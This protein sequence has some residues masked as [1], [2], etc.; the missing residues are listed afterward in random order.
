M[1]IQGGTEM[2]ILS[3]VTLNNGVEMPQLGF[4]VFQSA[5]GKETYQAVLWALEAGYRHIDTAM[6]YG[7]E[8]DVG[9]AIIDSGVPREEIFL[10]TKLWNEDMRQDRQE[11]A[12]QESLDRLQV[13][14]VDLY[15]IHWPVPGKFHDSWKALERIYATGKAKAIGVSNFQIHHLETIL[16]DAKIV[17]A[18]NQVELSPQLSQVPLTEYCNS[19]GIAVE[20]WSPLGGGVLV[21]DPRLAEIGAKY[22]K[23]AVQVILRWD[24]QRGIIT[25][26]KSVHQNR[27]IDNTK[28]FDFELSDEDMNYINS[29]NE[30]KRTGADPDTFNF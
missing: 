26:P 19:K 10:T 23:S 12:F 4:G 7:N 29:L 13:D 17:P 9:Q 25:I 30:D 14:Y 18:V 1:I 2:N 5:V 21:G 24:L 11:E 16:Q 28:I 27:I 22:G 20:A 3:T 15:L 8:A 6:I